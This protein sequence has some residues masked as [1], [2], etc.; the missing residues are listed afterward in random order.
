MSFF[1]SILAWRWFMYGDYLVLYW[2]CEHERPHV[3]ILDMYP[4]H[5]VVGKPR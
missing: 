4:S 3:V 5:L 2:V 1:C